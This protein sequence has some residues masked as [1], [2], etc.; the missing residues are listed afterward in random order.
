MA[1]ARIERNIDRHIL[2][3]VDAIDVRATDCGTWGFHHPTSS[4]FGTMTTQPAQ[5]HGYP[6]V[7]PNGYS[8][9]HKQL[10]TGNHESGL[11][12]RAKAERRAI[13]QRHPVV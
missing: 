4:S 12:D 1:T 13:L 9:P 2:N 7:Y 6:S 5:P 8:L 11:G 3:L 10:T